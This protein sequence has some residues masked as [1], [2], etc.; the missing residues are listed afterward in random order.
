MIKTF[1]EYIK[2]TSNIS[3]PLTNRDFC[4]KFYLE[5]MKEYFGDDVPDR[6]S[7]V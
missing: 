6:K 5:S 3:R 7:V 1:E 2:T 4:D